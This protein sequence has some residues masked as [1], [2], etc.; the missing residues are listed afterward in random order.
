ML[1]TLKLNLRFTKADVP[2]SLGT[3]RTTGTP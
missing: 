3:G 1:G 2:L